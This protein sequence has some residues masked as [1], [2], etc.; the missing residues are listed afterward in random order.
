M[1]DTLNR[2]LGHHHEDAP[3]FIPSKTW[4][5]PK[6][7]YFFG[8]SDEKLGL[9]YYLDRSRQEK[10]H[11]RHDP[12]EDVM[13][14]KVRMNPK[15]GAELLAEAEASLPA[16]STQIILSVSGIRA[17]AMT[18]S[19]LIEQNQILRVEYA[20][21][22]MQFMES[23]LALNEAIDAFKAVAAADM[24]LYTSTLSNDSLGVVDSLNSLLA[25][26]NQDIAVTTLELL[27]ELIDLDLLTNPEALEMTNQSDSESSPIHFVNEFIKKGGLELVV[28]NLGRICYSE[29]QSVE[30][31]MVEENVEAAD[32]VLTL[33]E[34]ILDL[35]QMGLIGYNP[36]KMYELVS[37]HLAVDLVKKT[38]ILGWLFDRIERNDDHSDLFSSI[39]LHAAELI[40]SLLQREECRLEIKTLS[41]IPRLAAQS[42]V[43]HDESNKV[44][45]GIEVLLQCIA[46]YRKRDP[47]TDEECEFLENCFDALSASLL[48]TTNAEVFLH[49]QGI[50]L[51]LRC[52]REKVHSGAGALKVLYFAMEGDGMV[53]K[54]ACD[55][56][57]DA[58]GF[59]NIFPVFIG[60]TT[61][62]PKPAKCSEAGNMTSGVEG[63]GQS[64]KNNKK[65]RRNMH[66]KK[67]W[68]GIIEMYALQIIYALTIYL[69]DESP[70][71]AKARFIAKF[72][73]DDFA[74]CDRLLEFLIKYDKKMRT[75]ELK[76]FRS[77]QAE[78]DEAEGLDVDLAAWNAKLKNGGDLFY[79]SAATL[80]YVMVHSKQCCKHISTQLKVKGSGISG[81]CPIN[82][83]G[84]NILYIVLLIFEFVK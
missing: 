21:N 2:L 48:N 63:K 71:D 38:K 78:I 17:A 22:P 67:A 24:L 15:T 33:I 28:M 9:G 59:K 40:S 27:V 46:K 74:K 4:Q 64:D 49:A 45:D 12:E 23:E 77:E 65:M 66:A 43:K 76:Y 19:K 39:K 8:S 34:T 11:Q 52:L 37:N 62:I 56:F 84:R 53:Y 73:E 31:G 47:K 55:I 42:D 36:G 6:P 30:N 79:R 7:G 1:D 82:C 5:G 13:A 29:K 80:S 69:N 72:V 3:T 18:L 41:L 83:V 57:V 16:S 25:H 54:K 50:E 26:D 75:A 81:K 10:K 51:M 44:I 35:E 58:G 60:R 61:A 32:N 70:H 20:D 68:L 14:K